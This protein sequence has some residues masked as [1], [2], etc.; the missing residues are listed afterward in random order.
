MT[1]KVPRLAGDVILVHDSMV[2][3]DGANPWNVVMTLPATGEAVDITVTVMGDPACTAT[4][5]LKSWHLKDVDAQ[6]T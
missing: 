2:V 1:S 6:P 3:Y 5:W 4:L